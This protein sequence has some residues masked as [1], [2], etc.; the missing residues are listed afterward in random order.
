CMHRRFFAAISIVVLLGTAAP[1]FSAP[2]RNSDPSL[3]GQII[4]KLKKIFTP[5][6][7]DLNDPVFPKP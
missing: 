3:V 4:L 6:L 1:A 2:K 5:T 7:L